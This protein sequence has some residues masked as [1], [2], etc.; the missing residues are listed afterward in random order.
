MI[1]QSDFIK[2]DVKIEGIENESIQMGI[3]SESVSHL[4]MILSTNLYQ[5]SIGSIVREY[6]SNAVDAN[7]ENKSDDPVI[8]KLTN[9]EFSVQDF[10]TG[11]DDKDFRNII[12][13]YGKSTKRDKSDQLGFYGQPRPL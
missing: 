13:K 2:N 5:D 7:I 10:G 9:A 4:M 3:D 11:L 12:S 1:Q 6:T 8:V